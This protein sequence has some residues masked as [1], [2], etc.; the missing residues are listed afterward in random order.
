MDIK[1]PNTKQ[2]LKTSGG[3]TRKPELEVQNEP[4]SVSR[5]NEAS[6]HRRWMGFCSLPPLIKYGKHYTR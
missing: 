1:Y 6:K 3:F 5:W 2:N 4:R